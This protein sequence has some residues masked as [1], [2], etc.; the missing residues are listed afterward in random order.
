M[1]AKVDLEAAALY[2]GVLQGTIWKWCRRGKITQHRGG[3]YDLDEIAAWLDERDT[4]KAVGGALA[5][6]SRYQSARSE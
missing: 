1:G 5:A 3:L 4:G 2:A 6:H